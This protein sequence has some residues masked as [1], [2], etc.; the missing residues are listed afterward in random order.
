MPV[1]KER[2]ANVLF[3]VLF[4]LYYLLDL[5]NKTY[6]QIMLLGVGEKLKTHLVNLYYYLFNLHLDC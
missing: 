3:L 6:E 2:N 4:A 5:K 1:L